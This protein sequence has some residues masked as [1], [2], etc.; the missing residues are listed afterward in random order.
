M[1]FLRDQDRVK[2]DRFSSVC[3]M[4]MKLFTVILLGD[5]E[6]NGVLGARLPALWLEY[7]RRHAR[8]HIT[9]RP[10]HLADRIHESSHLRH[11]ARLPSPARPQTAQVQRRRVD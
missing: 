7:H 9:G 2:R 1:P 5:R 4:R 6:G 3:E 11:F 10:R 8:R